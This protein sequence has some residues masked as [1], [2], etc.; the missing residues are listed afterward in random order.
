MTSEKR[1]TLA[2]RDIP[3][4]IWIKII[5]GLMV[6]ISLMVG[7]FGTITMNSLNKMSENVAVMARDMAS[8][9]GVLSVIES[10]SIRNELDINNLNIRVIEH[11][12][13]ISSIKGEYNG[14]R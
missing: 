1:K 9:S 5:A 14:K 2:V 11:D 10:R 12:R 8:L 13:E 7:T 6:V 4:E 3:V